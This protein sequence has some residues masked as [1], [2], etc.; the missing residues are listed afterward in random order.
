MIPVHPDKINDPHYRHQMQIIEI[1][2]EGNKTVLLNLEKIGS[3]LNRYPSIIMKFISCKLSVAS[4]CKNNKYSINGIYSYEKI[5]PIIY[6]FIRKYV[7]C[8]NCED[9]ETYFFLKGKKNTLYTICAACSHNN[10]ISIDDIIG[11]YIHTIIISEPNSNMI[12]HNVIHNKDNKDNKGDKNMISNNIISP[13]INPTNELAKILQTSRKNAICKAFEFKN[14]LKLNNDDFIYM[15]IQSVIESGD[16]L[17]PL[18]SIESQANFLSIIIE[19]IRNNNDG[20]KL[21]KFINT[22]SQICKELNTPNIISHVFDIYLEQNLCN[23]DEIKEWINTSLLVNIMN[24]KEK[25]ES[26]FYTN[27]FNY[28]QKYLN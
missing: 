25:N 19:N 11:S 3:K 9:P 6:D 10:K 23:K 8:G 20:K 26:T 14:N 24:E 17:K 7:I 21:T 13:H 4:I 2:I 15:C 16:K 1:K 5:Q 22:I 12:Y 18:E 28:F 27:I